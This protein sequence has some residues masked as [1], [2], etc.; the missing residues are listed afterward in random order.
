MKRNVLAVV[1][2]ALMVG[3]SSGEVSDERINNVVRVFWHEHDRYS[4]LV[5][6]S[7]G[8]YSIVSLPANV[9]VHNGA[10]VLIIADVPAREKMWVS[11]KI[12]RGASND[13]NPCIKKMEIHVHSPKDVEGAAWNHGK[14]GSGQT[15]VIE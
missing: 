9:C 2:C 10:M 5:E 11:A 12:K 7:E 8:V 3:C 14:F 6:R 4:V 13:V 1:I 15:S